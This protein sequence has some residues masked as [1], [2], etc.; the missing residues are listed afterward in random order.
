M[1]AITYFRYQEYSSSLLKICL[2]V[3]LLKVISVKNGLR[4][5]HF[6]KEAHYLCSV[7]THKIYFDNEN[8]YDNF[9]IRSISTFLLLEVLLY[10]IKAKTNRPL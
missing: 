6:K 5:K 7:K 9:L 2:P 8:T 1:E 3:I 4:R 10:V